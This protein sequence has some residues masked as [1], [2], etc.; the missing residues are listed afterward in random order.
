MFFLDPMRGQPFTDYIERFR[1]GRHQFVGLLLRQVGPIAFV[2]GITY[3]QKVLLQ[4]VEMWPGKRNIELQKM[5]QRCRGVYEL[6]IR[7]SFNVLLDLVRGALI[8]TCADK[9]GR[10]RIGEE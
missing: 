3:F 4:D 5:V 8:V 9:G 6:V 1:M 10:E 7:R 2:V